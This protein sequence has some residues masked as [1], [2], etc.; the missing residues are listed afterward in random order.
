MSLIDFHRLLIATGILFC[1]GFGGW[2]LVAYLRD[3]GGG[4]LAVG[5]ASAVAAVALGVYLALLG[6]IL[7]RRDR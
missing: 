2:Q 4:H 5:V 7:G 1:S 3:G 6:R